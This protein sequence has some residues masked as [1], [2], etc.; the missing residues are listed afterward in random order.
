MVYVAKRCVSSLF[1]E[2]VLT[3]KGTAVIHPPPS[4][5]PATAI[6]AHEPENILTVYC[7]R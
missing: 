3:V 5:K 4:K 6:E 2:S 1:M 7:Y